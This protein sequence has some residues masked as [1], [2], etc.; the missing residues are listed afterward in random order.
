MRN[1]VSI[2]DIS[3][4]DILAILKLALEFK[5]GLADRSLAGKI[6]ASCFFEASTRTRLSFE[7]A[8]QRLDGKII[9]FN[10]SIS[11]SLEAKGESLT[12]TFKM[13]DCYADAMIIRHPMDG[14]ARLASEICKI[15][16]INAGDGAN[17]HPSQTLLDL[18]TILDAHGTLEG[19]SLGVMGDL[20]YSR[21]VHSLISAARLFNMKLY[22]ISP[23]ELRI[24][25]EYLFFL[26][27]TSTPYSFHLNIG[28]VADKLDFLYLTRVQKERFN[29]SINNPYRLDVASL[30]G[31]KP[32]LKIMHPLPRRDE[33]PEAIDETPYAYYFQQAQ[34]GLFVRQ[35]L[36]KILLGQ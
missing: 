5:H 8:V 1:L 35:A 33:L 11:T 10:D 4:E 29:G 26:K 3:K 27:Q 14:A 6:V 19:V 32:H 36:L 28:E 15:P 25:D 34:N 31:V 21:T 30:V 16:V 24:D 20:K 12:D 23:K 18:F 9:G 7:S 22:L 13:V 17:Q 2:N